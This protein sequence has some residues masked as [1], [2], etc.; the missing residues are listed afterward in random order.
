MMF[1]TLP[2]FVFPGR[3]H[4]PQYS[5]FT[6]GEPASLPLKDF[7]ETGY[8][9]ELETETQGKS[10][11]FDIFSGPAINRGVG[12]TS[13]DIFVDATHSQVRFFNISD[14]VALVYIRMS[15]PLSSFIVLVK[16]I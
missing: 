5:L 4:S 16:S 8:S 11:I 12:S 7:V 1:T 6:V 9:A 14:V 13:A 10:G 15:Y 2:A 3:S